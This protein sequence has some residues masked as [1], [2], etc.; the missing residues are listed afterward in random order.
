LHLKLEQKQ[1]IVVNPIN[2]SS[3]CVES[4]SRQIS[5][6]KGI[7]EYLKSLVDEGYTE[8]ERI[9]KEAE[10]VHCNLTTLEE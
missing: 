8:Y 2:S 10:N 7:I 1:T 4:L 6:Q 9:H 3:E 5:S